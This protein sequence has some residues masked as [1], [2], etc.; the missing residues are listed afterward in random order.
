MDPIGKA[1]HAYYFNNDTTFLKVNSNY[2]EDEELDP[3]WFFR[4]QEQMPELEQ[5]ALKLCKG[6][7]LDVGA[8][9]GAHTLCLQAAG[10]EVVALDQSQLAAEVMQSRGIKNVVI[11]NIF[12]YNNN[13]KFDTIVLLMNGAGIAGTLEGLGRLLLHLKGLLN[14]NGSVLID[15]SDIQY[16]FEEEDGSEWIDL[17]REKYIGEMEYEVS[18]HTGEAAQ[19][20]WLF[21]D[22]QTLAKVASTQGFS[23]RLVTEGNSD[24]YLAI[25]E[26]KS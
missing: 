15:S 25:L 21:V 10:L 11:G 8:G 19:F 23:C 12:D 17:T 16:L 14:N 9:A 2:T 5:Q 24:N 18:Y 7:I 20:N 4:D 1:I 22:F 13:D 26:S 3:A 6:K